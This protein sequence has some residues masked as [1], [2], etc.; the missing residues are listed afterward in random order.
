M[1]QKTWHAWARWLAQ[2]HTPKLNLLE[3]QTL[4]GQAA[5]T[6][7]GVKAIAR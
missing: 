4:N 2:V 7:A 1:W 6:D 5:D 3:A